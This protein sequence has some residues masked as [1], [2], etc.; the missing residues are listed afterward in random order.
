MKYAVAGTFVQGGIPGKFV[1]RTLLSIQDA[2]TAEEAEG[3][4][5]REFWGRAKDFGLES[6]G[7]IMVSPPPTITSSEDIWIP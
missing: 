7:T 1:I 2:N 4:A 3:K 6:I 5:L